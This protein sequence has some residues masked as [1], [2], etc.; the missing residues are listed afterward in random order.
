[1]DQAVTDALGDVFKGMKGITFKPDASFSFGIEPPEPLHEPDDMVIVE[2]PCHPSEPLK[3]PE[4]ATGHVHCFPAAPSSPPEQGPS[5][6]E[7]V[8]LRQVSK[9]ARTQRVH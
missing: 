8:K 3:V 1:M 9:S 6:C 5:V 2:P 4:G 7:V